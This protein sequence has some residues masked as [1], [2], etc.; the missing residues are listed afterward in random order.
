MELQ[1]II[2]ILVI[3]LLWRID[4]S[5]IKIKRTIDES[6]TRNVIVGNLDTI[7]TQI[8]EIKDAMKDIHF[9]V[10]SVDETVENLRK[11]A[12]FLDDTER[13]VELF[14]LTQK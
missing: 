14:K 7:S 4:D 11:N 10:E 1:Y 5:L 2:G 8:D 3:Y 6:E 12:G 9:A 13:E